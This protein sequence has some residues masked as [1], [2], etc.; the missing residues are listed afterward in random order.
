LI[1]TRVIKGVG[2]LSKL[3]S[4]SEM[5][6]NGG[7][8]DGKGLTIIWISRGQMTDSALGF[9]TYGTGGPKGYCRF[10]ILFRSII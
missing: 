9:T 5:G 3:V 6:I 2:A 7:R 4:V 1:K 8:A 10:G